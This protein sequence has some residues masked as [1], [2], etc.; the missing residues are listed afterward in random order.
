ML[1]HGADHEERNHSTTTTKGRHYTEVYAPKVVHHDLTEEEEEDLW[2]QERVAIALARTSQEDEAKR[3]EAE[4]LE[5]KPQERLSSYNDDAERRRRDPKQCFLDS[6][7]GLQ[8]GKDSNAEWVGTRCDATSGWGREERLDER[9]VHVHDIVQE[10]RREAR[11]RKKRSNEKKQKSMIPIDADSLQAML[12]SGASVPNIIAPS[13]SV[14]RS[15]STTRGRRSR[16][17]S[18]SDSPIDI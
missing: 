7:G 3:A 12:F 10:E 5:V 15:E 1:E 17:S 13:R 11:R 18:A 8:A 16:S 4:K 6:I 14:S 2:V 9:R